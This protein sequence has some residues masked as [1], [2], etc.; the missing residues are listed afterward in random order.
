MAIANK[1]TID[2]KN[3][4]LKR[5]LAE[6]KREKEDCEELAKVTDLK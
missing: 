4:Q 5:E 3:T 2:M 6:L 1:T